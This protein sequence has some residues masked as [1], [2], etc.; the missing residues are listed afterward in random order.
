MYLLAQSDASEAVAGILESAP[1]DEIM[2]MFVVFTVFSTLLLITITFC[3][4]STIQAIRI[5]SINSKL[6]EKLVREGVPHDQVERLV[7]ANNRRFSVPSIALPSRWR[8][9][10]ARTQHTPGKPAP[11]RS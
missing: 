5:A 8:K 6:T 4:T 2:V 1:T 9:A 10:A 11:L 3:V 7:R